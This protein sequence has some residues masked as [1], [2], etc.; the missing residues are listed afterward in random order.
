MDS[1]VRNLGESGLVAN[2]AETTLMTL[3]RR[4]RL[5]FAATQRGA[6]PYFADRKSL[7]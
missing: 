1:H 3:P 5:K 7:L 4:E 2:I 6:E